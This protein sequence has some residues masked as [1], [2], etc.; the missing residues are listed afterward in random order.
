MAKRH[1]E[2]IFDCMNEIVEFQENV[3]EYLI[4]KSQILIENK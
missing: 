2:A 1:L 4:Y 3:N